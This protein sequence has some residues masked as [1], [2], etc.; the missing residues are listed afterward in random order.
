MSTQVEELYDVVI[1]ENATRRIDTIIGTNLKRW[2]G[3]G[4][5]RNSVELRVQ[6]GRER[7]NVR[8]DCLMV[9]AGKYQP[10]NVLSEPDQNEAKALESW[11]PPFLTPA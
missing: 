11:T 10:G 2:D 7:I 6:T 8:Y 1:I 9:P 3:T 5:G 4:T